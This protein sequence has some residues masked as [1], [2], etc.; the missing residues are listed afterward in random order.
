MLFLLEELFPYDIINDNHV[1]PNNPDKQQKL[2]YS[3]ITVTLPSL[4]LVFI[5]EGKIHSHRCDHTHYCIIKGRTNVFRE[6]FIRS[7]DNSINQHEDLGDE[8]NP[9]IVRE[10]GNE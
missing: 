7:K 1:S 8:S 9:R 2:N 4:E 10:K 5:D 3:W 6:L